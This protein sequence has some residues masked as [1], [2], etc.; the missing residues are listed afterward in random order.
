MPYTPSTVPDYVPAE[1]AERWAGAW[2]GA[3]ESCH[4]KRD[5][6][7][8]ACEAYAF[9]VA[10]ALLKKAEEATAP[11]PPS[12]AAQ[13]IV[14]SLDLSEAV[15]NTEQQTVQ[16][17][18][19][20]VGRSANGRIYDAAVL[21][22]AAPLFENVK[23]FADHPIDGRGERPERSVR[24]ITGWLDNVEFREDGLYATRHFTRNQAGQDTWALVRDIVEGRA[25]ATLLGGSINAVGRARRAENGDLIVESIEAVHSVDDVTAPA[26]GGQFMPLVA[27]NDDL[28]ASLLRAM[29]FE[30]YVAARPEFV[31]RLK[32]EWRAVRQTEAVA[33]AVE[34]RDQARRAL[35]EAQ[36]GVEQKK[37]QL[38]EL[39]AEVARLR[40]ELARKGHEVELER[41]LRRA[42]LP[43]KVE[44]A[45]RE[46]LG[47][48][49]SSQ[50]LAIVER[51]VRMAAMLSK[52]AAPVH[53]APRLVAEAVDM[54]S[55]PV[56]LPV[57]MDSVRTL[58][59][60]LAE[61]RKR[62]R[63]GG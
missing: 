56:A 3:Y 47:N 8:K 35:I 52:S 60:F 32:K 36:Q 17:R 24:Q 43:A 51:H 48:T 42:G 45:L 9:R 50:W 37:A 33:A 53:G 61:I 28:T 29:T 58:D 34:E 14:E 22:R 49:D 54:P 20:R 30:E 19:I 59:D 62:Q 1:L 23:T 55:A 5:G 27:G 2:N 16:Q 10:N 57:D 11:T 38:S 44:E 40:A 7:E 39:E 6:D 21:R 31:E 46:E 25:P 13:V 41:A 12:G 18:I 4:K 15:I 26:A 63:R